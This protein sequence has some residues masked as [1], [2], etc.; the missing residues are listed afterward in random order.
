M[1]R[2]QAIQNL[3]KIDFDFEFQKYDSKGARHY[4]CT[5]E[6]EQGKAEFPFFQGSAITEDPSLVDVLY[7]LVSDSYA[8]DFNSVRDFAD[9]YGY[10]NL[11]QAERIFNQCI[12]QTEKLKDLGVL[13][14]TEEL[15]EI[16]QDY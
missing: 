11:L 13:E 5:L 2:E 1:E 10:E 3:I 7:C 16:F 8:A 9:E 14:F 6:T 4:V 15:N 12:E